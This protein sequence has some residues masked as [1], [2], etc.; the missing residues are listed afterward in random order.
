MPASNVPGWQLGYRFN[1]ANYAS[2][3][4]TDLTGNGNAMVVATGAPVFET[5]DTHDGVKLDNTWNARFWHPN[6]WQGTV[7]LAARMERLA[8]GT[9][10]R[11]LADFDRSS[12]SGTAGRLVA[13][14]SGNDRR[15][16]LT[17]SGS[18]TAGPR[19]LTDSTIAAVALCQD[20]IRQNT[21][22]TLDGITVVSGTASTGTSN[23]SLYQMG[24][25]REGAFFGSLLGNTTNTTAETGV[26]IHAFEMHFFEHNP[27][28]DAAAQLQVFLTELANNYA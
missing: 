12:G 1:A 13:I 11:Y 8:D 19:N 15:L 22:A 26:N 4:F 17:S 3:A 10:V 18:R 24:S 20:Q 6:S 14:F 23:G 16:Q 28:E 27:I 5:V 25:N 7:V 9:L 2:G 21:F